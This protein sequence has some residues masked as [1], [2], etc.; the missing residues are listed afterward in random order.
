[1]ALISFISFNR[2]SRILDQNLCPPQRT[3]RLGLNKGFS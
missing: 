3:L 2:I 1:M